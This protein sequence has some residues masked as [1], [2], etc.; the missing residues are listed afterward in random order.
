MEK[1][2]LVVEDDA[3][4]FQFWKRFLKEIGH[5]RLLLAK[6]A[7]EALPILRR[8]KI[9]LLIS[10]IMLPKKN[11]YQLAK[12]GLKIRRGLKIILTT[13]YQTK[14]DRYDLKG[15]QCHILHKPYHNLGEISKLLKKILSGQNVFQGMDEDSFSE[16]ETYP[17]ITEWML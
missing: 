2:I 13:G 7:E 16:N 15:L 3:T 5:N 6:N 11:G 14:L 12:E 9:D 8:E 10:D 4:Y 17:D 1:T